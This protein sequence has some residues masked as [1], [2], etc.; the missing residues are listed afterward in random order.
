MG[1]SYSFK[2]NGNELPMVQMGVGLVDKLEEPLDNGTMVLPLV[3]RDIPY[4]MLGTLSISIYD[5][6]ILKDTF[7][8]L[9]LNDNVTN[10][11]AYGYYTHSFVLSE[12]TSKLNFYGP[13]NIAKTLDIEND[14]PAPFEIIR[15]N[16]IFTTGTN[17]SGNI[18]RY[19]VQE[20]V[21]LPKIDFK[22]T[23]RENETINISKVGQVI[24]AE[25]IFA[26]GNIEKAF[27]TTAYIRS[28]AFSEVYQISTNDVSF[29]IPEGKWY[30]DYGFKVVDPRGIN[31]SVV[32]GEIVYVYRYYIRVVSNASTT[33]YDLIQSV[34]QNISK[35]GGI[36][37][38]KFYD[39]TR[40]FNIDP[41]I[42]NELKKIKAPQTYIQN[43]NARQTLNTIFNY[44]NA[45]TRL[46][47]SQSTDILTMDKFNLRKQTFTPTD[48]SAHGFNQTANQIGSTSYSPIEMALPTDLNRPTIK[49]PSNND[50]KT[51]RAISINLTDT[52]FEYKL[53][54]DIYMIKKISI[55][56][57]GYI[58]KLN[59]AYN[60]QEQVFLDELDLTNRFPNIE[61]WK[62]KRITSNFPQYN[63][64]GV[65]ARDL[66]LRDNKGSN[67]YWV[68][69]QDSIN[70]SIIEGGVVIDTRVLY[71]LIE[72]AFN[73]YITK[74]ALG[75]SGGIG[76]IQEQ[77]WEAIGESS[78]TFCIDPGDGL[79][80]KPCSVV[81]Q[82]RTQTGIYD[83]FGD[84]C[85]DYECKI[86]TAPGNPE[87]VKNFEY[88]YD[89]PS[90]ND[91]QLNVE[92]ISQEDVLPKIDKEDIKDFDYYAEVRTNQSDKRV[93]I[94][95]ETKRIFGE[96]QRSGVP[97]QYFFKR[98]KKYSEIYNVGDID[99]NGFLI[100]E[101]KLELYNEYIDCHY[102]LTK[103]HNKLAQFAGINQDYRW[104]QIP[105]DNQVF[106]RIENYKDYL[107]FGK[108]KNK[109]SISKVKP[110]AIMNILKTL[111]S[112]DNS[113]TPMNNGRITTA[114][115]QTDGM[116]NEF[117]NEGIPTSSSV[118]NEV[119]T[120][121]IEN[122]L[123]FKFGFRS[124]QVAGD[125]LVGI[126]SGSSTVWYNQAVR[127][128]DNFGR[129]NEMFFALSNDILDYNLQQRR[130]YPLYKQSLGINRDDI[131][132]MTGDINW[133]TLPYLNDNLI[134]DKDPMQNI[135][136]NYQLDFSNDLEDSPN[137]FMFGK[138]FFSKNALIENIYKR[139]M[140]LYQYYNKVDYNIFNKDYI[141]S[142]Y[143]KTKLELDNNI[144]FI[145]ILDG[146]RCTINNMNSN[147]V[148]WAIGDGDGNAYLICNEGINT[149]TVQSR[150]IRQN[151]KEIG[152]W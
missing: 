81:G 66:G 144:S 150:H 57:P 112:Y 19:F 77:K 133:R 18:K 32:D 27:S 55:P 134:I 38:K 83:G 36:E 95:L 93:N 97:E 131:M 124:N 54:K 9:I 108:E 2:I 82:I 65:G 5:N 143:T 47:H 70:L 12:Y 14:K 59:L 10:Q 84:T 46:K 28:N 26:T 49:T 148:M 92:Y 62:L 44:V 138:S 68:Q 107:I 89:I 75:I 142:G 52:S 31:P 24:Q 35:F 145:N 48:I 33:I 129:F 29:T 61:E 11:G 41:N 4:K 51:V 115:I 45:I 71:N 110:I 116:L 42:V 105:K 56:N 126:T 88:T 22:T 69:G 39:S 40:V 21:Y 125:G 101:R 114:Y 132:F 79:Q 102:I 123:I 76:V 140:F 90:W 86:T 111:T 152:K 13:N 63:V 87:K 20:N 147:T 99:V 98:A 74:G 117:A 119:S 85:V 103:N 118:I 106:E 91:L 128:T 113:S 1:F 58:L 141:L 25:S 122:G 30:I 60:I 53:P 16:V 7:H 72:E 94:G 6:D 135:H 146:I 43:A 23:Y 64:R 104:N 17:H 130:D 73:E 127:Y 120:F 37:S 137:L 100:V 151:I 149:F 15:G 96:M 67:L 78:T 50:G 80:G 8:Y 34:R 121:G 139:E 3:L 109:S 136:I